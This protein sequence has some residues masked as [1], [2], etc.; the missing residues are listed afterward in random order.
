M[1]EDTLIAARIERLRRHIDTLAIQ[2]GRAAGS[3]QLLPVSKT[4]GAEAIREA[5][6]AGMRRFG[7]NKA[8]EIRD[9]SAQLADA[10][11]DW[12]MIGHLQ[13]NKAKDIARHAA[14]IQSLDR[15]ELAMALERRLQVEGRRLT[16]LVQVKTSNEPS[17]SGLDPVELQDFLHFLA[18]ETPSLQVQGLMTLA[19]NDDDRAAVR[20]CFRRLRELRDTLMRNPVQG[21]TLD[22]LSMGMSG[23]YDLAI[24]EGSTEVRIGSAIFGDRSY[25][26][27]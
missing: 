1:Q 14:E 19:V 6:A 23:D 22:R 15:P 16:A 25:T 24:E 3:V 21:I 9:K 20:A 27:P 5:V 18:T 2:A 10:G 13:T 7:E 4:F 8:Q 11:V 12:V 26:Q 17:K